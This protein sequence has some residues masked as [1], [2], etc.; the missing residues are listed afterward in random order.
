MLPGA[1]ARVHDSLAAPG[2]LLGPNLN[3]R[4]RDTRHF[5]VL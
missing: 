4:T 2:S 5:P 3:H 1:A